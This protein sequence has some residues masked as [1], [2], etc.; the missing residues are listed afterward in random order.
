[1]PNI[2][3]SDQLGYTLVT[4]RNNI[5]CDLF[6]LISIVIIER[7]ELITSYYLDLFDIKHRQKITLINVT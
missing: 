1:M 5:F 6:Y 4:K 7:S 2:V 3:Q